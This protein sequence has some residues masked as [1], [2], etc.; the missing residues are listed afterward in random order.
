MP[1]AL[2]MPRICQ[3]GR[4]LADC[5]VCQSGE[6]SWQG[7][8]QFNL[9]LLCQEA[10]PRLLRLASAQGIAPDTAED[11]VQET[12]FEAWKHLEQLRRPESFSAWLDGICRNVCKRHLA[13]RFSEV[14][15]IPLGDGS[16]MADLDLPDPLAI[17]LD[18]A[19]ERQD[20]QLL[21]D[22]AL[23]Y[24]SAGVREA[25]ELSYL[26]ELPQ[27]DVA[28]QLRISQGALELKLYRARRQLRQIL[29][30]ELRADASAFG[31]LL[32]EDEAMSWHET[33]HWCW[34]CGKHYMRGTFERHPSGRRSLRLRCPAC[35]IQ[36]K[37]DLVQSGNM[38]S[39][40]NIHAFLPAI[41]RIFQA[42]TEYFR[43]ALERHICN[44]CQ[45]PVQVQIV[46]RDAPHETFLWEMP[47]P[48]RTFIRF[49]CPTCGTSASDLV[50]M[51]LIDPQVSAFVLGQRRPVSRP[52]ITVSY[53]GQDVLCSRLVDLQSQKQ[54]SVMV[55][56]ET[57]HILAVLAE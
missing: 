41:K 53:A 5:N 24:L 44:S 4:A 13:H 11:V 47:S 52:D 42:V 56:P 10:R 35:S 34:L 39:L 7:S 15:C 2:S 43:A 31:L 51:L 16:I 45:V 33:R 1:E 9:D 54:L 38:V 55:H 3:H 17:D 14:P 50:S 40:E 29:N 23:G 8:Q 37:S 36:H 12:L 49:D 57:L 48:P 21:L 20:K 25:V 19:L 30:S 26:A 46:R 28:R 27:R 6:R 32:N 18:E 22:R